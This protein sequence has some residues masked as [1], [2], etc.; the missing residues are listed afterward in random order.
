MGGLVAVSK[1]AIRGSGSRAC[2]VQ[3]I[4]FFFCGAAIR[5]EETLFRGSDVTPN[6]FSLDYLDRDMDFPFSGQISGFLPLLSNYH[7]LP[8]RNRIQVGQFLPCTLR[9]Y[10]IPPQ[11]LII[12][13]KGRRGCPWSARI[14]PPFCEY[15]HA[16]TIGIHLKVLHGSLK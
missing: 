11:H 10:T 8:G 4:V 13:P 14:S 7:L 15:F 1:L 12:R 2:V 16:C 3:G 5:G 9:S 6:S